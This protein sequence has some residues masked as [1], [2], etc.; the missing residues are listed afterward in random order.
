MTAFA[1][2]ASIAALIFLVALISS[3]IRHARFAQKMKSRELELT[4]I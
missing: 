2:I 1:I 4:R 3:K